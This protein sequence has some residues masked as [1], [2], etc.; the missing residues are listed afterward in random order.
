MPRLRSTPAVL[1]RRTSAS[2]IIFNL[3][4]I[5]VNPGSTAAE[6]KG[7]KRRLLDVLGETARHLGSRMT[8][9]PIATPPDLER[10]EYFVP[11]PFPK[12]ARTS[13]SRSFRAKLSEPRRATMASRATLSSPNSQRDRPTTSAHRIHTATM[14]ATIMQP[15]PA[16]RALPRRIDSVSLRDARSARSN[17]NS[18]RPVQASARRARTDKPCCL[19]RWENEGG[20]T[21]STR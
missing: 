1:P 15:V 16:T 5:L 21:L 10:P 4:K 18:S 17:G 3:H 14:P 11:D 8:I 13:T 20:S 19:E 9:A 2:E 12:Q 6:A 7:A